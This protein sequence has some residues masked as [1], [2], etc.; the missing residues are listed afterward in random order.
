V[1]PNVPDRPAAGRGRPCRDCGRTIVVMTSRLTGKVGPHD[2]GT[3]DVHR[4]ANRP[5]PCRTCG[6]PIILWASRTVG[7]V[8]PHNPDTLTIHYCDRAA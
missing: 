7:R 1:T 5:R 6:A 8:R 2:A 3:L 4:C